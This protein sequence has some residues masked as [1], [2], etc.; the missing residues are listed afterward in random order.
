M[1]FEPRDFDFNELTNL[2]R[3]KAFLNRKAMILK[4]LRRSFGFELEP[5]S[6]SNESGHFLLT[7]LNLK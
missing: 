2:E 3:F 7:L 4:R 1:K 5:N 6:D